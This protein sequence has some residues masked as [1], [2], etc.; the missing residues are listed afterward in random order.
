[1]KIKTINLDDRIKNPKKK[2]SLQE[3]FIISLLLISQII[4]NTLMP[5][6]LGYYF[7][8]TKSFVFFIFM[9]IGLIFNIQIEYTDKEEIKIK[10][11]RNV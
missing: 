5:F 9:L 7:C 1:M 6:T 8:Q 4:L 3:R 2:R 11:L 10:V